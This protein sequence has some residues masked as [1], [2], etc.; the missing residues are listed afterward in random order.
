MSLKDKNWKLLSIIFF[1]LAIVYSFTKSIIDFFGNSCRV[2]GTTAPLITTPPALVDKL[3]NSS[4]SCSHP[5]LRLNSTFGSEMRGYAKICS[6]LEN[7]DDSGGKSFK[8]M[9]HAQMSE[10]CRIESF[11]E[12]ESHDLWRIKRKEYVYEVLSMNN[13]LFSCR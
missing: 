1:I 6:P 5:T 4:S 8:N 12:S 2:M 10:S 3:R 11:K 7:V 13:F 9:S